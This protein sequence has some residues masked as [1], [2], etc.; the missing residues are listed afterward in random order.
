MINLN[1]LI[2]K[3]F[4]FPLNIELK[5]NFKIK[6]LKNKILNILK[7]NI[8]LKLKNEIL[9]NEKLISEYKIENNSKINL[10]LKQN[11]I[12][13]NLKKKRNEENF[14]EENKK[15]KIKL[16]MKKNIISKNNNLKFKNKFSDLKIN[17]KNFYLFNKKENQKNFLFQI[18]KIKLNEKVNNFENNLIG[19]AAL[20]SWIYDNKSFLFLIFFKT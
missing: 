15:K 1:I 17:F 12:S 2:K 20:N 19:C 5:N 6:N 7:N 3:E 16:F 10:V 13:K 14:L 9:Q 18:F 4:S 8:E 11:F